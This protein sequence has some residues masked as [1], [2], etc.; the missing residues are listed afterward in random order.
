[1]FLNHQDGVDLLCPSW[2]DPDVRQ[3]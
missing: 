2:C 1:L 3:D